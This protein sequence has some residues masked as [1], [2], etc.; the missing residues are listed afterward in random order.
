MLSHLFLRESYAYYVIFTDKKLRH[1]EVVCTEYIFI[2][3]SLSNN[4]VN[5]ESQFPNLKNQRDTSSYT[6]TG[7]YKRKEGMSG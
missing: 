3:L 1:R 4:S 6:L 7:F 5:T 2:E